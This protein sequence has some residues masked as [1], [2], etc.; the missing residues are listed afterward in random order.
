MLD[1]FGIEYVKDNTLV[2]GLD[3]YN[4]TC[5]EIKVEGDERVTALLG[6]SQNTLIA[7]GRYDYLASQFDYKGNKILPAIGWAGGIDR[8]AI[9]LGKLDELHKEN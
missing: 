8:I 6:E 7:G 3:Y 5:F 4:G 2:R 9:L 1:K